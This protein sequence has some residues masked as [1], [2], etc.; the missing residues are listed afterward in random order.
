[1]RFTVY[2]LFP[3]LIQS[4]LSEG[5]LARALNSGILEVEARDLRRFAGN[6]TNRVDDSPYGGGP[7]MVIRVE[8]AA[9][10]LDEVRAE[11]QPPDEVVLLSPAGQ[12]LDQELVRELASRRHV[13]VLSGRYEG[14]D[15][16]VESLVTREVSLGDFVLMGGELPALCLIEAVTRLL[17]GAL[18]DEASHAEDSFTASLLDHPSYTRPPE[19][20]GMSVPDVL[21][22]GHHGEVAVWRRRQALR[23][24]FER[25]P[26]L[27]ASADLT[28]DERQL[29]DAWHLEYEEQSGLDGNTAT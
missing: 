17:P 1:M 3:G 14:F 11:A 23:R 20:R 9:Q 22:S 13:C 27:L 19:F 7:G 12:P 18:G 4:Y 24:T 29:I 16:R 2:S 15:A 28:N 26:D 25:R 6:R 8:V 5:L 10:A 21:L